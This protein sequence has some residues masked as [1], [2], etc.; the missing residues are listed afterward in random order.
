[1]ASD[2]ANNLG[3]ITSAI[4]VLPKMTDAMI[5]GMRRQA[6]YDTFK[7][8]NGKK[9]SKLRNPF[10]KAKLK[11]SGVD[12]T[13]AKRIKENML[14]YA[15]VE[16]GV[17]WDLNVTEWQRNDPI[18]FAKFYDMVQTQAERAIVSGSRVGNK[19]LFKDKYI[20]TQ[21]FIPVQGLCVTSY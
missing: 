11:A 21:A 14:K 4:N 3:K 5:R 9:F 17:L 12:E 10:S 1:M 8:A 19:N 7:W 13:L 18:S 6:I 15:K 16:N 2:Y 20:A